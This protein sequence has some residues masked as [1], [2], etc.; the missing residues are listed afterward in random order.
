MAAIKGPQLYKK[1]IGTHREKKHVLTLTIMLVRRKS[2]CKTSAGSSKIFRWLALLLGPNLDPITGAKQRP[3]RRNENVI[4]FWTPFWSPYL[5]PKMGSAIGD[6]RCCPHM[7]C[8]QICDPAARTWMLTHT[9]FSLCVPSPVATVKVPL[10]QPCFD[11]FFGP[12]FRGHDEAGLLAFEALRGSPRPLRGLPEARSRTQNVIA[13]GQSEAHGDSNLYNTR[14]DWMIWN[15]KT[16]WSPAKISIAF[17]KACSP[18]CG[19]MPRV[20]HR[21]FARY[22]EIRNANPD[23]QLPPNVNCLPARN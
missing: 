18:K 13:R 20:G 9:F 8:K 19:H 14:Q 6:F 2:A 3:K 5:D 4:Q 22:W 11:H 7:L 17:M 21:N 12:C 23:P 16:R 1:Q 10:S 15:Q